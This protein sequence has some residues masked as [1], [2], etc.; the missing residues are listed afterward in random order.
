MAEKPNHSNGKD[1][2]NY[3]PETGKYLPDDGGAANLVDDALSASP[4]G[5]SF[6][7]DDWSLDDEDGDETPEEPGKWLTQGVEKELNEFM[8]E[9]RVDEQQRPEVIKLLRSMDPSLGQAYAYVMMMP[10]AAG[11][12]LSID[13]ADGDDFAH[14]PYYNTIKMGRAQDGSFDVSNEGKHG[15]VAYE[16]FFHELAHS[17]DGWLSEDPADRKSCVSYGL[18]REMKEDVEAMGGAEALKKRIS[19]HVSGFLSERKADLERIHDSGSILGYAEAVTTEVEK[20]ESSIYA[21]VDFVN[22]L[23]KRSGW[24]MYAPTFVDPVSGGDPQRAMAYGHPYGYFTRRQGNYGL[25]LFA[26][27]CQA[28]ATRPDVAKMYDELM[29]KTM[30]SIRERIRKVYE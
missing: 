26:E 14:S 19:D 1:V 21:L 2:Q 9:A 12:R 20:A 23:E 17:V 8:E 24:N 10:N 29:P 15:M 18:D 3:D 7:D 27:I 5:S 4:K 25:E 30:R 11:K 13:Y 6:S 16:S 22:I 28:M